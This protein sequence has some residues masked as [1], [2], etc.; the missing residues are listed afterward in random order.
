MAAY[1]GEIN[2]DDAHMSSPAARNNDGSRD[3]CDR[4]E[5][6]RCSA[7]WMRI[8]MLCVVDAYCKKG[9]PD[10]YMI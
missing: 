2:I 3:G 1:G 9:Q 10:P 4:I 8:A 7:W 6:I 5:M